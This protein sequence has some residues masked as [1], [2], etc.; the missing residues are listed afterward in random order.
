MDM[1]ASQ[2]NIAGVGS[3][4]DGA[5][6]ASATKIQGAGPA[7]SGFAAVRM[8][9]SSTSKRSASVADESKPTISDAERKAN[10]ARIVEKQKAELAKLKEKREA[11]KA[12]EELKKKQQQRR[13]KLL[14]AKYNT[15][16]AESLPEDAAG[17]GDAEE[18]SSVGDIATE[19]QPK[20][21]GEN[22]EDK[23]K[24]DNV[25][26][27]ASDKKIDGDAEKN[28]EADTRSQ[29]TK[30]E[31]NEEEQSGLDRDKVRLRLCSV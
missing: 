6:T 22:P 23:P 5:G 21:V 7:G 27:E 12:A 11:K 28:D 26:E 9:T 8:R 3:Q 18:S 19:T 30:R 1:A 25:K 31:I 2:S 15:K 16:E 13:I 10:N 17:G 29:D 14:K 20:A 24:E 4:D